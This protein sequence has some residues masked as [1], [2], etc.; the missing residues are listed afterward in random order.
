MLRALMLLN[1][2]PAHDA[3]LWERFRELNLEPEALFTEGEKLWE[4][5]G[6]REKN[7]AIMRRALDGGWVDRE[8]EACERRGVTILCRE[9][10]GYPQPLQEL[11]GAPLV[12]YV[13]G[14]LPG[15]FERTVGVVGTRRCSLYGEGI[16]RNFGRNAAVHGWIVVSGGAKGVD[17]E[18]HL[19]ALDGDGL[20]IAVLG[21][22]VDVVYPAEHRGL[23]ARIAERGALVSEFP[24]GVGGDAWRFPMRNRI[25][26]GLSSRVVVVEAPNRSGAM[27]TAR[28]A[29]EA[30]REVWAVPG[31]IVDET[32]A[33]S[34]R[35]IFD[36][37]IPLVDMESF[38]GA[39][40]PQKVLF[41]EEEPRP[42]VRTA[43][44]NETERKLV[45]LLAR[46]ADRTVDNLAEESGIGVQDVFR[47]M[48][49]LSLRGLVRASGPGR[50]RLAD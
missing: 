24:L 44:L 27:I 32:C 41:P 40:M 38:F 8:L 49:I 26:A 5:I 35:L 45:T 10:R 1:T 11:E 43:E 13:K 33:G 14:V 28:Q 36:G 37:A 50:Y 12:L 29:G 6:V 22:G 48:S 9:D 3:R 20:T 23:F 31:R 15:Q 16:A 46:G 42:N 4:K 25:I 17:G 39:A 2:V 7:C 19:G 21:T 30:G 34:N 47:A 18:A